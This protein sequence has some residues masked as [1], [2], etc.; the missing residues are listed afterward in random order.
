MNNDYITVKELQ[1][2]LKLSKNQTYELV[3]LS[4][5]P[6]IKIGTSIRIPTQ[7]LDKYLQHNLY[8]QINIK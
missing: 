6:K 2:I 5:F 3:A 4:D 7:E 1:K 8:K